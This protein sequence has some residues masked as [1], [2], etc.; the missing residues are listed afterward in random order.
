MKVES[1]NVRFQELLRFGVGRALPI[2][3]NEF[4]PRW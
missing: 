4:F 1:L 3:W 2:E